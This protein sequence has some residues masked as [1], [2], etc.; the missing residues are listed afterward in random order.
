[1]YVQVHERWKMLTADCITVITQHRDYNI[2]THRT[3]LE[4]VGALLSD[5]LEKCKILSKS[6]FFLYACSVRGLKFKQEIYRLV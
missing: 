4:T 2:I 6:K 1:M 3:V 5:K